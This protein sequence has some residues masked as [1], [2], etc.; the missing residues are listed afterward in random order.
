M[1]V[2]PGARVV[3]AQ[4][5][6]PRLAFDDGGVCTSV[7]ATLLRVKPPVLATRNRY[8]TCC[9]TDVIDV[10]VD[11]FT[12]VTA[13]ASPWAGMVRVL[14]SET[15]GGPVGGLPCAVATLVTP[16]LSRSAWVTV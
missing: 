3:A 6:G 4:V 8:G 11:D 14:G 7:T 10:V 2:A 15:T 1:V 13:A 5:I 16:L 12:T 9:P